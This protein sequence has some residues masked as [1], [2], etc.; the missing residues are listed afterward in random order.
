MCAARPG[1]G[2]SEIPRRRGRPLLLACCLGLL[3]T[4]VVASFPA[5]QSGT[6]A[7]TS[8]RETLRVLDRAIYQLGEPS[9]NYRKVLLDTVAA[10]PAKADDAVRVDVRTFLARAPGPGSDFKCSLDFVRFRARLALLRIRDT[11]RK[12]YIGPLEPAVCYAAPYALDVTRARTAGRWLDIY[13]YDFDRVT[14]EMILVG[15]EGY[16]D[17]TAALV[18]KSHF[19][20]ALRL[21]DSAVPVSPDSVSLGLTWRHVIHHSIA[22][23]QPTSP[24]C[25]AR[26]EMIPSG[27][28]IS[29]SPPRIGASEFPASLGIAVRADATLDYS[30]NKLEATIC[31]AA[32]NPS[33]EAVF[34]GCSVEFLYTTD[35]DWMIEA[36]FGAASSRV[37]YVSRAGTDDVKNGS[38]RGPVG[39]WAF[40]GLQRTRLADNDISVTARLNAITFVSVEDDK[41]VSPLAYMEAT[42]TR[43]LSPE[44]RRSLD[45]QLKRIDPAI[46]KLRPRFALP[47]P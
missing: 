32:A 12:D 15:R 24:L 27:R 9:S 30:S 18:A 6:P 14:P 4:R 31:M 19:H 25:A 22:I 26:V 2:R 46:P 13:G 43:V 16:R 47:N 45:P 36:V 29:Y 28:T 38:S 21:G 8:L 20:L 42:R 44:T 10:L 23:V 1:V 34:S 11:L 40:T 5:A 35:P 37:S 3:A 33:R 7:H 17:V 39:Q 41:C